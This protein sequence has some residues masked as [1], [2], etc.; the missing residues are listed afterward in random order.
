MSSGKICVQMNTNKM[1]T[2]TDKS[3]PCDA[4]FIDL[5]KTFHSL[6]DPFRL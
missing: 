2:V 1:E 5:S 4:V 6:N 3:K